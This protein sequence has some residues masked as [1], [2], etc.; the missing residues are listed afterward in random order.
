MI[1]V[2]KLKFPFTYIIFRILTLMALRC[3][4]DTMSGGMC[5]C[6]QMGKNAPQMIIRQL[7]QLMRIMQVRTTRDMQ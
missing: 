1:E 7:T 2:G 6:S 4:D 5:V 3:S